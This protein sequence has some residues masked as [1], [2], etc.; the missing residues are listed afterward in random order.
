MEL[1]ILTLAALH[2]HRLTHCASLARLG[3]CPPVWCLGEQLDEF[4]SPEV[5]IEAV[6][7]GLAF[8]LFLV[9]TFTAR[10]PFIDPAIFRD[11]NFVLGSVA[12][13]S[14]GH[15]GAAETAP[16][17]SAFSIAPPDNAPS[18]Q[19]RS[20]STQEQTNPRGRFISV[21]GSSAAHRCSARTGRAGV[22]TDMAQ[23][24]AATSNRSSCSTDL[25]WRS[26]S[27]RLGD[28]VF[29]SRHLLPNGFACEGLTAFC[30]HRGRA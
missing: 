12:T 27:V 20:L 2:S 25:A 18:T 15:A 9:Q 22:A 28:A 1:A 3:G 23:P 26:L 10:K 14:P 7:A 17:T 30:C 29:R 16:A 8:Y 4:S 19:P 21:A 24:S 13:C 5:V 11:R 6:V